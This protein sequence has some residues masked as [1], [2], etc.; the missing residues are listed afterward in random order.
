LADAYIRFFE[1][2]VFVEAEVGLAKEAGIA[3][4]KRFFSK[5]VIPLNQLVRE[6]G[7]R[8]ADFSFGLSALDI[9]KDLCQKEFKFL[10]RKRRKVVIFQQ[11]DPYCEAVFGIL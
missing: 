4:T 8:H 1:P 2:D 7:R 11:D 10:S 3:E 6:D 9:Y 5:R